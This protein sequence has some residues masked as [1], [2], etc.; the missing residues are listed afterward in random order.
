MIGVSLPFD[1]FIHEGDAEVDKKTLLQKLKDEG[2]RSIELRT[3]RAYHSP[4]QVLAAAEELWSY[5]FLI[6]VHGEVKSEGSAVADVFYPLSSILPSLRQPKVNITIHP[7][8]ADNTKMLNSLADYV[9]EH[10]YPVTIALENNRLLPDKTE[11]DSALLVLQAVKE[12]DRK[13]IGICFDF[14]HYIYYRTKNHPESSELLPTKE[15]FERVIHTH[16]HALNGLTTHFP[17]DSYYMPLSD[18]FEALSFEYFG[19]YNLELEF[20]RFKGLHGIEESLLGSLRVLRERLPICAGIYDEVRTEFDK[21]F[22]S[23]LT[24]LDGCNA[25]KFGLIHSTSYLFNTNG[26]LWGMD[27]AFRNARFL[28]DTPSRCA[29]LL[30]NLSLMVISHSHRD[31]FEKSTIEMLSKTEMEWVIPDFLYKTAVEWGISPSKIHVAND[32]KTLSVGALKITPFL[33]RH[34]RPGT[35]MGV[36]EYGYYVTADGAPSLVF[37]VDVR[38][39]SLKGLPSIPMADYCFANVWLG[40]RMALE[41]SYGTRVREFAEFML[42]FSKKNILLTHLYENGRMDKDMWRDSHAELVMGELKKLSPDTHV[43]APKSGE[44]MELK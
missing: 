15:F 41:S 42:K 11:G 17:L 14:G 19:I 29:E 25:N 36:D 2:V 12:A 44:V 7:I 34:F 3:V 16:I 20:P 31:H 5:G 32:G 9:E 38:D 10:N 22:K 27:I 18:I 1:W 26:Y 39:F 8:N 35:T 33:S 37:P 43:T 28:A 6:S 23:A 4:E 24:A 30:K 21:R 40:D 13:C